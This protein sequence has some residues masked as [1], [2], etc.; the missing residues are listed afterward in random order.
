[1]TRVDDYKTKWNEIRSAQGYFQRLDPQHP[2]DFF[3][4][5]NQDGYEE[6]MLLSDFEPS[7]M[8]SSKSIRVEKGQREDGRW[9]VQIILVTPEREDVF[10]RL[11]WD[12][13]ESSAEITDKLLGIETVITRFITWQKLME[14]ES[15]GLSDASIKGIVGELKYAEMF[16]LP[17]YGKDAVMESWL[18]PEGADRDF[19]FENTWIEVKAI[20]TGRLTVE[21]SSLDQ[22]E[23]DIPGIL[24]IIYVDST[25]VNDAH[26][27]SFASVIDGFRNTL[28]ASP[29]ALFSLEKKLANLGY[30]DRK[31]YS[32]KFYVMKGVKQY[33]VDSTFPKLTTKDV[34]SEIARAKYELSI[35]ALGAWELLGV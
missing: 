4:G 6:L 12:L 5:I 17:R 15:E 14:A 8:K 28:S 26:G 18:G 1:M 9:A 21:I 33:R 34:R 19:V 31:E 23:T 25:S 29:R 24:S 7:K 3:M 30:Y 32:E 16:L 11:C 22:L 20:S 13:V 27:F 10:A 35:S 2:L